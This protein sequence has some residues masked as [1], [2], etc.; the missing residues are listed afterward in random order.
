MLITLALAMLTAS[1]AAPEVS[2][3]LYGDHGRTVSASTFVQAPPAAVYRVLTDYAH[4]H[5]FMPMVVRVE[6]LSET[7]STAR[8][9]FHFRYLR[10]FDF[11]ETDERELEPPH[12]ISFRSIHGPLKSA[13]G[14]WR[15][16]P[17]RGGTR[18]SYR[19]SAEPHFAL[20]GPV[21]DHLVTR[22]SIDLIEGIRLRTESR[23]TWKR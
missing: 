2:H 21:M 13:S 1:T 23:G 20:P 7:P 16:T 9:M 17:E 5:E 6:A 4:M 3:A 14:I 18:L 12:R 8:V 11:E 19:I 22:A 10:F 15:M